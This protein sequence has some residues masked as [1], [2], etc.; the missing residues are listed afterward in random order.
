MNVPFVNLSRQHQKIRQEIDK[1][2]SQVIDGSWFILGKQLEEFERNFAG[3]LNVKYAFGVGNGTDAL[4]IALLA[5]GV[6]AGDEVLIPANTFISAPLE[7]SFIGAK[8][9]LIDI[10]EETY[11]LDPQKI[12]KKITK[13]TKAIIPTH[14][15]GQ[16]AAMDEVLKLARKYSLWVIEDACQAHGAEYKGRK[17]G[18][19]GDVGCFSFY[20]IKNLGAL[21]DGGM[22]V[23]NNSKIAR[24][25]TLLRNYGEIKKYFYAIRGFNSRLD[26]L[27][28][29]I[30]NVKLKYLSKD[31]EKRRKIAGIYNRFL[32]EV[33]K[34]ILP[35]EEKNVKHIYHLYMIRTKRRD[36]LLNYLKENGII[37]QIHYP[38]PIHL[39][40]S[41]KYLG[42]K[43]GDLPV[44]EKCAKEILSLPIF[45]EM[46]LKEIEYVCVKI[47]EFFATK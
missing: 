17:V 28:A 16:P 6:K 8:P 33:K 42:Y 7:T 21:G 36:G 44:T 14:L 15:C 35:K 29:V 43:K 9:V 46:T 45:P 31:N 32:V 37:T 18:G 19:L 5:V 47:K 39:Q 20:P 41:F 11:N 27:Q 13:K 26:P 34:I 24:K 38:V 22:I 4:R 1:A 12:E 30:L 10:D 2:I 23:T 3:Y 25:I 40:Q